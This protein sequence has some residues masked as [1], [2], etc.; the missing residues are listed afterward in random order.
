MPWISTLLACSRAPGWR[1]R[2]QAFKDRILIGLGLAILLGSI[3]V[4]LFGYGTFWAP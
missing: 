3:V 4:L 2:Y 1:L